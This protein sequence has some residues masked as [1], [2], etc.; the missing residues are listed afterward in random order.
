MHFGAP[1]IWYGIPGRYLF[2][3]EAVLKRKYPNLSEHPE[4]LYELV[5]DDMCVSLL[6]FQARDVSVARTCGNL[7]QLA[8]P[9]VYAFG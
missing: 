5:S 9:C 6:N 8:C 7:F 3:F 4:L 1:K 2:K